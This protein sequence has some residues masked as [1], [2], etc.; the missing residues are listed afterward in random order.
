LSEI[1]EIALQAIGVL[2]LFSG[3]VAFSI[4]ITGCASKEPRE[5]EIVF[6]TINR[7]VPVTPEVPEALMID[8]QGKYPVA[9]PDG[10]VCFAGDEIAN[11]QELLQF[12]TNQNRSLKELLR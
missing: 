12:L 7:P 5:P 10:E 6:K 3:C 2:V 8:Y 11:L 4:M 1:F 9:T